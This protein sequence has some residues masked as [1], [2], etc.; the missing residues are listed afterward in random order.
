MLFWYDFSACFDA[1]SNKL[2]FQI[3][4]PLSHLF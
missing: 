4:L 3:K 1:R 2:S